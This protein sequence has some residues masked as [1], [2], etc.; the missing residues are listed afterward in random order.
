M[1]VDSNVATV[2]ITVYPVNDRPTAD[3]QA[4]TT[5]EEAA[6]LA[7]QFGKASAKPAQNTRSEMDGSGPN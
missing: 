4:V 6:R 5:N 1:S 2:L 3:S 7:D